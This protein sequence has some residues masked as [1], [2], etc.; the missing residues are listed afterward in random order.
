[1]DCAQA[2]SIHPGID[3]LE[4]ICNQ[5]GV[6]IIDGTE[7]DMEAAF[8]RPMTLEK[9]LL[10]SR[11]WPA[12]VTRPARPKA[13]ICVRKALLS[14]ALLGDAKRRG[15]CLQCSFGRK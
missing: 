2:A 14:I 5:G 10:P 12:D 9:A 11:P 6:G 7:Q 13:Y 8:P 4:A 3:I 15:D 1:M